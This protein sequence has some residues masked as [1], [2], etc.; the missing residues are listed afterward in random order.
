MD[1]IES[2]IQTYAKEAVKRFMDA[3]ISRDGSV[4]ILLD[5]V[6]STFPW[7][8]EQV[9]KQELEKQELQQQKVK[10]PRAPRKPKASEPAKKKVD[11]VLK[12][13]SPVM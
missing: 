5:D 4:K 2:M 6:W 12:K 11:E 7:E 13:E 1:T 3:A 9:E 8:V 10:K